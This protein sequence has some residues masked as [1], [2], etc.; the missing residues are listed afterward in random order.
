MGFGH[1]GLAAGRR[2][3]AATEGGGRPS[4]TGALRS[5]P[6]HPGCCR[7]TD[8]LACGRGRRRLDDRCTFWTCSL[9][10]RAVCESRAG[11]YFGSAWR[12]RTAPQLIAPRH[13]IRH[14]TRLGI[15]VAL[16]S[17]CG[18]IPA[19]RDRVCVLSRGAPCGGVPGGGTSRVFQLSTEFSRVQT[20]QIRDLGIPV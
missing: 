6:M 7:H 11:A 2:W 14:V 18:A 15:A 19:C 4:P 9:H 17:A 16:A 1:H 20:T 12:F 5:C 13:T 8:S 3:R 10:R